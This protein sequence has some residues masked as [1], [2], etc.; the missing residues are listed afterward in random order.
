MDTDPGVDDA[1]AMLWLLALDLR[2]RADITGF[3]TTEGNLRRRGTFGNAA[4]LLELCR[5]TDI[6]LAKS[7]SFKTKSNVNTKLHGADGLAGLSTL[8][9]KP[10]KL[11]V[12]APRS[13]IQLDRW[14]NSGNNDVTLIAAGPMTNLDAAEVLAPGTL[15]NTRQIIAM[16]GSFKSGNVTPEAEFNVHFNPRAAQHVLKARANLVLI[17]LDV[18]RQLDLNSQ[19]LRAAG[20]SDDKTR[21]CKFVTRLTKAMEKHI[22]NISERHFF[23]HDACAVAYAFYP[24]F[25]ETVAAYVKIDTR[26]GL[27]TTGKTTIETNPHPNALVTRRINAEG[28]RDKMLSDLQEFSRTLR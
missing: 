19:H 20:F 13:P 25:F 12:E 22:R 27:S 18:S 24:E 11:Y 21:I 23:V 28:V 16:G 1:I 10:D 3:S 8:L 9:P 6:R 4:R 14:I 26:L 15:K 7:V 17:P 2:F 5:R